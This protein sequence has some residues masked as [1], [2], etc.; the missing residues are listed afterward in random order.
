[1][2]PVAGDFAMLDAERNLSDFLNFK[3]WKRS[4][5]GSFGVL[6]ASSTTDAE[7]AV[8]KGIRPGT[9]LWDGTIDMIAHWEDSTRDD[10][11]RLVRRFWMDVSDFRASS[12]IVRGNNIAAEAGSSLFSGAWKMLRSSATT[13]RGAKIAIGGNYS[14]AGDRSIEG[15]M[16]AQTEPGS[17]VLPLLVPINRSMA[18]AGPH[19]SDRQADLSPSEDFFQTNVEETEQRRATRTMAQALTAVYQKIIE[20]AV[21]PTPRAI[22]EAVM[23]GASRELVRA[24]H[25]IV[26]EETVSSFDVTF[27]WAPLAGQVSGAHPRIEVPKE[28]VIL[29]ERAAKQMKSL[30]DPATAILS[31]PIFAL[32]HPKGLDFGEATIEAAYHGRVRRITVSLRGATELD[33]AHRWFHAHETLLVEGTVRSTSD[34]LRVDAPTQML[35]VGQTMLFE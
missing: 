22:N 33:A 24:L 7:V 25:D 19:N 1:M 13:S 11:D 12:S 14:A 2:T 34:G 29:L 26:K 6:W 8:P 32:Y 21:E 3:G 23:A 16:F 5:E 27:S 4:S 17:Y 35:P 31:G 9:G 18:E 28:S 15:A 30:K 10:V 20:P